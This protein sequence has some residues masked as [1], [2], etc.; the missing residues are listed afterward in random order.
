M[1]CVYHMYHITPLVFIFQFSFVLLL[2]CFSALLW[3]PLPPSLPPAVGGRRVRGKRKESHQQMI[4]E[5]HYIRVLAF[6]APSFSWRHER[7]IGDQ[8]SLLFS[9]PFLIQPPFFATTHLLFPPVS[10]PPLHVCNK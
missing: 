1:S 4:T 10:V 2:K 7:E 6:S 3:Y 9:F 5:P 8:P